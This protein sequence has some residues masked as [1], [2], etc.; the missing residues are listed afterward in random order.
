VDPNET[1]RKLREL[2]ASGGPP[3]FEEAINLFIELDT[4]LLRGGVPPK[5]W[6]EAFG[7]AEVRGQ[8]IK[9]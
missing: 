1:L 8:L 9:R 5:D 3:D 6:Q 2:H 4:W 7:P